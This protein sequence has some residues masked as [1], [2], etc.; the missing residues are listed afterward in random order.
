M[1]LVMLRALRPGLTPG[2]PC[3]VRAAGRGYVG[4][5]STDFR[6]RNTPKANQVSS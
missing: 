6:P 4:A 5:F 2:S 1:V 3:S